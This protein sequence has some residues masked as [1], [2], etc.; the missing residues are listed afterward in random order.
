MFNKIDSAHIVA[1]LHDHCCYGNAV[2]CS[3][4]VVGVRVAVNN[5]KMLSGAMEIQQW[6]PFELLLNQ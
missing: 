4:F 1:H 2:V 5:I 3:L 6:V